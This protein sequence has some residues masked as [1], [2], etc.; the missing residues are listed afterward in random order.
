MSPTIVNRISSESDRVVERILLTT[1]RTSAEYEKEELTEEKLPQSA[2]V[3]PVE[4][5]KSSASQSKQSRK[6]QNRK[7]NSR[8]GS[9]P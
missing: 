8:S 3:M 9:K 4:E 7:M 1:P 5:A 6:S 2:I